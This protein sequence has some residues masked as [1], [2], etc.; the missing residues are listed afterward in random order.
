MKKTRILFLT[1]FLMIPS[2]TAFT[3]TTAAA[4]KSW[5]AFWRQFSSAVNRKNKAAVKR[6]MAS[7]KD[8][9]SGGGGETRD[10]WLQMV[11]KEKWWGLLQKS[12]RAGVKTYEYDG[13]P[14]RVTK[15]NRMIFV[16]IGGRWRF[17]GPMGD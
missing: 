6:L 15:D 2:A 1:L 12:V 13:R 7:E 16:F 9:S 3:Q 14:S 11:D 4:N 8:F 10:E 17:V 5:N